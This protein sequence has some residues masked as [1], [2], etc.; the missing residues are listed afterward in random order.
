MDILIREAQI[1]DAQAI[2]RLN[3]DIM[4][5]DYPEEE[6]KKKLYASL[7]SERD[8]IYVAAIGDVVVGYIHANDYDVLYFPTMKNIMGIAVDTAYRRR[9]I[10]KALLAAIEAWAVETGATGIRLVSGAER[11]EAHVFYRNCGF[12]GEKQQINFKKEF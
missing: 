12:I 3:R 9:G 5:Y 10:G 1:R 6:T 11:K 7:Q 8:K 2:C 4:G